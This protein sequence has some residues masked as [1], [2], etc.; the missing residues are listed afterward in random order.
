MSVGKNK[1]LYLTTVLGKNNTVLKL[2]SFLVEMGYFE[3]VVFHFLF[4]GHTKNC[5]RYF[6]LLK[7]IHWWSNSNKMTNS[8]RS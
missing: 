1:Q 7:Q 4:V 8:V 5:D 6:N 3:E 2:V